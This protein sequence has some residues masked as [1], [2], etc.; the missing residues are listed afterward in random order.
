MTMLDGNTAALNRYEI[1]EAQD[2][3]DWKACQPEAK[4]DVI[5]RFL[6]RPKFYS[7]VEAMGEMSEADRAA[8]CEAMG[9]PSDFAE[10]GSII[11]RYMPMAAEIYC[12]TEAGANEIAATVNRMIQEQ[13]G[14]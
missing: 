1:D 14:Y 8:F 6:H 7:I 11:D 3:R 4:R 5:D 2:D 9:Q 10:A 13:R 12:D